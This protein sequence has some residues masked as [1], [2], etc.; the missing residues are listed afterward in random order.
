MTIQP[1]H[2]TGLVCSHRVHGEVVWDDH[3]GLRAVEWAEAEGPT[4]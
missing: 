3:D 2:V 4:P 1:E